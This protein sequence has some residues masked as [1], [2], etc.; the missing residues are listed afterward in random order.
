MGPS[1]A[2]AAI[3]PWIVAGLTCLAGALVMCLRPNRFS[4]AGSTALLVV[5]AAG[6]GVTWT[7][8]RYH[9]VAPDDLAAGLA[10]EPRLVRLRG[11][12]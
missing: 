8:L 2:G 3:W 11:R 5:A 6:F 1:C 7:V 10:D 12:T 9:W 4:D